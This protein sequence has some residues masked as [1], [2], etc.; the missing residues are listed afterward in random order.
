MKTL[1]SILGIVAM[2]FLMSCSDDEPA[3]G[4][5]TLK[6][7]IS[8]LEDLGADARYEGWLI[9]EGS[10][11][12]TGV[13]SVNGNG[14]LSRTD[15]DVDQDDLSTASAFVLTIEPFPDGDPA[16]SGVR[17]VAGDFSGGS[18][19]LS[20]GHDDAIG[21]DF[22]TAAGTFL[23]ATP[24][25]G[26]DN[27]ENSGVWFLMPSGVDRVQSLTLPSLPAEW[28]YEGWAVINGIPVTTGKFRSASGADEAAPF[29]GPQPG[30]PFPGEDFLFNAPS[31]LT[32]P[33]DLSGQMIVITVEPEPDNSPM[34]FTLKPLSGMVPANA[35][36]NTSYPLTFSS[37]SF[38][39]GTA[40]R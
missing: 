1:A 34:P 24:T 13:F 39:T 40:S 6:L 16:P 17:L 4:D 33:T 26:M 29:S 19:N 21:T 23:L 9:V 22:A 25:N 35:T 10:P 20:I 15:F 38:P 18:A 28:K 7:N 8:G 5:G 11:V 12:S 32:F 27:N 3:A 30:P 2:F 36:N 31:G 14:M 37:A